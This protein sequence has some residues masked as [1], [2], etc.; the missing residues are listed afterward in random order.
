MARYLVYDDQA[1][2]QDDLDIINARGR[3]CYAAA[4]WTIRADG[5]VVGQ[6]A[7][8]DDPG[9]VTVTWDVV[10]QRADGK[11]VIAHPEGHPFA[12]YDLGGGVTVLSYTMAGIAAPAEEEAAEWWPAPA[13]I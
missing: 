6:R 13:E 10:R 2:A 9:G 12:D 3:E 7:G 4:G 1:A 8:I 5:A 11:W